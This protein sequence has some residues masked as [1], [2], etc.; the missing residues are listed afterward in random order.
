MK[1]RPAVSVLFLLLVVTGG[2]AAEGPQLLVE[3]DKALEEVKTWEHG[4]RGD[5]LKKVEAR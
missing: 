2:L 4:D 3:L 1:R 5:P